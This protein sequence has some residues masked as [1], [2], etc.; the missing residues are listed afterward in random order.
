M[1]LLDT[2]GDDEDYGPDHR[3]MSVLQLALQLSLWFGVIS[4]FHGVVVLPGIFRVS[5]LGYIGRGS[6]L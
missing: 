4:L 6:H 2:N 5:F 3:N 1:G